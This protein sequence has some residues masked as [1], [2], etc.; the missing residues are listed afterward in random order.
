MNKQEFGFINAKER[1]RHR[2]IDHMDL[3][4]RDNRTLLY[5]YTREHRTWHVYIKHGV[6]HT[7]EYGFNGNP[8][9]QKVGCSQYYIPTKFLCPESCDLD[10]C[11]LLMNQGIY[12]PFTTFTEGAD[13]QR[14]QGTPYAG[15][16][17]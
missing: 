12:L 2:L 14:K 8:I 3:S 11:A 13:E 17:L 7:V 9:E 16:T 5:G 6:I 1:S 10:F 15:L 4:N